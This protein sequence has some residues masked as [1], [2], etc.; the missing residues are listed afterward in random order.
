MTNPKMTTIAEVKKS[1]VGSVVDDD[2]AESAR[3]EIKK[4]VKWIPCIKPVS[5]SG[6][7][8]LVD[9]QEKK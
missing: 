8:E 5:S 9:E 7:L 4:T 3:K 2:L 1:M 6:W